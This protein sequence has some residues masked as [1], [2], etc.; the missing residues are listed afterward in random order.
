MA[1]SRYEMKGNKVKLEEVM[2]INGDSLK[3]KFNIDIS[4]MI[5]ASQK[6]CS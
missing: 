2:T 3:E 6:Y 4:A 5:R 1:R